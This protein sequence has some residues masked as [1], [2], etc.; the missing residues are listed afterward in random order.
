MS[1]TPLTRAHK[2]QWPQNACNFAV[3]RNAL[4]THNPTKATELALPEWKAAMEVELDSIE[5]NHMG[6]GPTFS[7]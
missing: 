3:L 6:I 7:W 5:R 1:F 4:Q 2:S